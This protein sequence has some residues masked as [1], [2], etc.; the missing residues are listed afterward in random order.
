MNILILCRSIRRETLRLFR[1]AAGAGGKVV[2]VGTDPF[3][4]A[5]YDAD[6]WYL[7]PHEPEHAYT[8]AVLNI[9]RTE[10]IDCAVALEPQDYHVIQSLHG[11]VTA[12]CSSGEELRSCF[13]GRTELLEAYCA[14]TAVKKL[15][16][17]KRLYRAIVKRLPQSFKTW[18]SLRPAYLTTYQENKRIIRRADRQI[19]YLLDT[20]N[21][22]N[23][24]DHAIA[25]AQRKFIE[26]ALPD[27]LNLELPIELVDMHLKFIRRHIRPDDLFC[28][29]GGGNFGDAYVMH[30]Y[31]KRKVCRMF[32]DNRVIV[33]P[34]TISYS[35]TP[36]GHRELALTQ[37]ALRPHRKLTITARDSVS[38]QRAKQWFPEAESIL[39]PDI[40]LSLAPVEADVPR[41]GIL[42]CLRRD[43]ERNDSAWAG[44][45]VTRLAADGH[46]FT[47][48]DTAGEGRVSQADRHG[49]LEKKWREFCGAELV[50]TDR[51]HGMIFACITST[52]CI[53]LD[54]YN[55]KIRNFYCSWLSDIPYIRFAEQAEELL[56]L[57][58]ELLGSESASWN[59]AHLAE[60]YAPLLD[61][62]RKDLA[63]E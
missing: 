23:L 12:L 24:G 53:V 35:D 63:H 27:A 6:S 44:D 54:N 52:P 18:V 56:P 55:H 28:F 4:D 42:C 20:P 25:F 30:E 9:C 17:V 59:P 13:P 62:L 8:E 1:S 3:A 40:V 31:S 7:L 46:S 26:R 58:R 29:V 47:L 33:F 49:A 43:L 14:E 2:A 60:K 61:T 34:Q 57:A 37:Q 41:K 38:H 36:Q 32:P 11:E 39:T 15:P 21:H 10:R 19:V 51:L 22:D 45:V 16:P 5:I 48:S 50:I